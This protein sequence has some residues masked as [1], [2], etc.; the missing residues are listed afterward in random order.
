MLRGWATYLAAA[1]VATQAGAIAHATTG[2]PAP[3][4]PDDAAPA[5]YV[6]QRSLPAARGWAGPEAFPRTSGTGRLA[7]GGFFWTDYLYDDHGATG[8]SAGQPAEVAGTPVFGTYTYPPGP[9]NNNG[10][11]IFTAAVLLHDGFTSWRVD[12]TTLKDAAVPIAEWTFDRDANPATGTSAWP[13]GAAVASPGIDTALVVS[14]RVAQ[15][16]DTASGRVLSR[17]P[18]TVDRVAQSFVVKVPTS[19]LRPKGRWRIR[20]AAGL[21]DSTGTTFAP[22]NGALPGEAAIY[23]VAFRGTAQ[24]P[25]ANNFWKDN[26]QAQAL[27]LGDVS[28][29]SATVD[30]AELAARKAT[31]EAHPTG[32]SNRW[33]VSSVKLGD[34][35]QSGFDTI[36]SGDAEFLGRVQPYAVYVPASYRSAKPAPLT[37]LLHSSTQNH[38]Q[39]AAT[40]P[41]LAAEACE[42][43]ASICLSPLGRGP[44]GDFWDYAEL[45]Y[46]E[47]GQEGSNYVNDS[48][49]TSLAKQLPGLKLSTWQSDRNNAAL[50][51]QVQAD[52]QSGTSRGVQGTPTLVFQGPKGE[53]SPS[54]GV[55]TYSD[56][57]Q[58]IKQVS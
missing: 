36:S 3:G 20:L 48:Y 17:L 28:P 30:W 6:P 41:R 19:T 33:Y 44:E 34:G 52:V 38:N 12:W 58:A 25:P 18:V 26:T 55:P 14:S 22:A 43:R 16:I 53:A 39:Y 31:P 29:F 49:L 11:D 37:W 27:T 7:A 50:V 35:V 15:L 57:Q 51:S 4:L 42:R 8:A 10:A 2:G 54:A 47:Q 46:N 5:L 23:N 24:E 40:T 1:L 56:L 9:A 21:A 32:W 13:N 45:F